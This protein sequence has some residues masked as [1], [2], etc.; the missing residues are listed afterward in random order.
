MTL[1]MTRIGALT[2][3]A[4]LTLAIAPASAQVAPGGCVQLQV[5]NPHPGDVI[6]QGNYEIGGRATDTSTQSGSGIDRVQVFV[7]NRDMGGMQVGEAD[8]NPPAGAPPNVMNS[9]LS[10][11]RFSV[12]ADLSSVD[13]GS[14]T[15]FVFARSAVSGQEISAGV[16]INVGSGSLGPA[17]TTN[18][19]QPATVAASPECAQPSAPVNTS[20]AIS[21]STTANTATVAQEVIQVVLDSPH[22]GASLTPGRNE[23]SGRASTNGA[24]NG[25]GIDRVQAFLGNR[26]L[27]GVQ[28]G[29]ADLTPPPGAPNTIIQSQINGN[30]FKIIVD[31]PQNQ[32]GPHSV[33]V[34]ARSAA[35]GKE[36][37]ATT[38]VN[39]TSNQ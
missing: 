13:Q 36:G 14:H 12:L 18:G 31:F 22:P 38:G 33:F 26:D 24:S 27:G 8:L 4:G 10:G 28:L 19:G 20:D 16:P 2:M 39:L 7:D 29:E 11:A 17:N 21:S 30:R 9:Q 5:D 23:V 32:A 25:G 35:S 3:A 6:T 15:L 34:Y 37:V 1:R